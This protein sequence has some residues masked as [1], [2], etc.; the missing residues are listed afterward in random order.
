MW[1]NPQ[2]IVFGQYLA[3]TGKFLPLAHVLLI[4]QK[5]KI[6]VKFDLGLRF[7][8]NKSLIASKEYIV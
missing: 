1:P 8:S 3:K 4:W 2:F 5:G 7:K 6:F